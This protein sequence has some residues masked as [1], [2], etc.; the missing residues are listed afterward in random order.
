VVSGI[1]NAAVSGLSLNAQRLGAAADNIVNVSTTGY[2]RTDI[3]AQ[4]ISTR[5]SSTAYASGGVQAIAQPLNGVQGLLTSSGSSTDLALSGPGYFAV[6]KSTVSPQGAS[7][8]ESLFTRD[9]SF[10][11]DNR[12]YLVNATGYYLLAQKPDGSGGLSPVNIKEIGGAA[13][14]TSN[15]QVGANLPATVSVGERFSINVRATDSLGNDLD[16]SLNFEAQAG[17]AYRLSVGAVTETASG[18]T[19]AVA[20]EGSNAGPSYDV[21]V[22]FS[23]DGTVASFDGGAQPPALNISGLAS[24]ADELN[25][26]LDLG[27]VGSANG[28]TRYGAEFALGSVQSDGAR[29]SAVSNVN[30]ASDG[31]VTAVFDNGETRTIAR[32]P[33]ATF[34]NPSGLSAETGGGYR[35]TDAS[36]APTYQQAGAGGA[37][38]VQSGALEQSTTDLGAEFVNLIVAETSYRASL[39]VLKAADQLSKSLLDEI[40]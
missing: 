13:E 19:P 21:A 17:G 4:S 38:H 35:A 10:A 12:G 37:G 28:L 16:I 31:G 14:A 23:A 3:Q 30:I 18:A 32:I 34:T 29:F 20:R 8:D 7:G 9:G 22:Q 40:A 11:P 24:G 36:G 5:Q 6:S 2:K 26:Q 39:E 33:I 27:Q 1:L 15:T 25:I